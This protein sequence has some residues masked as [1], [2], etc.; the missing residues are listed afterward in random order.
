MA[1]RKMV[2]PTESHLTIDRHL[3]WEGSF[4]AR[5]L[6]GFRTA[7][8]GRTRWG[9]VVRADRLDGLTGR[10]WAALYDHGT[11]TIVDLRNDDEI[12]ENP[13]ARPPGLTTVRVPLDD[14]SDTEFWQYC[15]D[16]DL[17]GSPL[18][19]RP[20]LDRKP[21]RCA[22]AVAAVARARPGGVV[23]HCGCGRDRTGLVTML[24]LALVGVAPEDIA[25]DYELS[26]ER[27]RPHFAALGQPDQGP[28]IEEILV[29]K[30]TSA[31]AL[32][33]GILASLDVEAYLRS[34][35][36]TDDDLR[37]VRARLVDPAAA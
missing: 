6:G 12:G 33:L 27:L 16:N 21:E 3:D 2:L 9:A 32:L 31:R 24:L 20:F 17:D 30:R 26:A 28:V 4:N 14:I 13:A 36:L 35:G 1:K 37:A 29:R 11:R 23:I 7:G 25:S 15:W 34:G 18:Y 22:A 8:G 10:G 5:D 19:Y